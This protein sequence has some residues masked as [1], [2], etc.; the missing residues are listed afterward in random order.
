MFNLVKFYSGEFCSQYQH[1]QLL[2]D[3][4]LKDIHIQNVL[5]NALAHY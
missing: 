1:A 3:T 4:Y 2:L 5:N